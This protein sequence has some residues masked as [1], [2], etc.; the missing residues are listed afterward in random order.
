M[1]TART[2][3]PQIAVTSVE[4]NNP[5]EFLLGE[6]LLESNGYLI[7]KETREHFEFID[8]PGRPHSVPIEIEY[9]RIMRSAK[10]IGKFDA[11]V[12]GGLGGMADFGFFS[13]LGRTPPE[14]FISQDASRTGC[15]WIV[16][17]YPKFRVIFDGKAWNVGREVYDVTVND[18]D[19][20]KLLEIIVP[21]TDFYEFQDKMSVGRIPLPK[22][23]FKY[24]SRREQYLP[25]NPAFKTSL[26]K[27]FVDF[28]EESS[29]NELEYR[30]TV[31]HAMTLL[32][33]CGERTKAWDLF[34]Q[35]YKLADK[36]EM[37]HRIKA[38]LKTQPVYNYIYKNQKPSFLQ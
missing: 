37:E 34:Q 7:E 11:N 29:S 32:I 23:I 8:E 30:S 13:F 26:L 36:Q 21:I 20:D 6:E 10:V 27:D 15:Q 28:S 5:A 17:L 2:T 1:E 24:D 3:S 25:V 31:L 19:N 4:P 16:S 38:I 22:I 12:Y 35:H 9:V 33:Y 14:L 18:L